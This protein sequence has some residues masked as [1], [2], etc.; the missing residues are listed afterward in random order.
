MNDRDRTKSAADAKRVRDH[1]R[2]VL[3]KLAA[4]GREARSRSSPK[5]KKIEV[6]R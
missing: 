6:D 2:K 4:L 5:P 1:V 3:A